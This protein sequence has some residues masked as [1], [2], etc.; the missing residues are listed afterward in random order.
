[1]QKSF[2]ISQV[3]E[4][5]IEWLDEQFLYFLIWMFKQLQEQGQL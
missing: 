5:S 4:G 1:M 2:E 3:H